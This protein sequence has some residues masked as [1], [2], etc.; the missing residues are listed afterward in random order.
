WAR[1]HGRWPVVVKPLASAAAEGVSICRSHA[2]IDQ[3][4]AAAFGQTTTMG[5]RNDE[6]LLQGYLAGPQFIVNAVSRNGR[7]YVTDAWRQT[8]AAYGEKVVPRETSLLDPTEPTA[9][10]LID[11]TLAALPALGIENGA[12][13]SELKWTPSGPTLIETGARLMGAA[14]DRAS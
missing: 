3:A 9:Q 1:A 7:H 13:H 2:D 14:M 10:A 8:T 12:S 4:F 6:L 5:G 11:Y